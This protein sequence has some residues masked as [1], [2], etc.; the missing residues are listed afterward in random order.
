MY[1][2]NQK[3][4]TL[5]ELVLVIT[6]LGILAVAAL[7]SFINV[8]SSAAY[9]A[10]DGTVGALR[11]GVQMYKANTAITQPN[12]PFYPNNLDGVA[13]AGTCNVV[14]RCF[15]EITTNGIDDSSWVRTNNASYVY[16]KGGINSTCTYNA[17]NGNFTCT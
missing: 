10:R 9:S 5:I 4:F 17:T 6:I 12:T 2:K 15:S 8:S 1:L 16:N 14:N 3:G 13:N 11:E 7:P